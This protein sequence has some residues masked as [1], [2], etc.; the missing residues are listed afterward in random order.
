MLNIFGSISTCGLSQPLI[1]MGSHRRYRI[2]RCG[3]CFRVCSSSDMGDVDG[4]GLLCHEC[5]DWDG[6]SASRRELLYFQWPNMSNEAKQMIAEF[7]W[8]PNEFCQCGTCRE[9]WFN[10]AWVCP[11]IFYTHCHCGCCWDTW[12]EMGWVCPDMFSATL[13][14]SLGLWPNKHRTNTSRKR[15]DRNIFWL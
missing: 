13:R 5:F 9:D 6:F 8:G 2:F 14:G 11:H 12:L 4:I 7:V 3:A 1:L 15:S 10:Q